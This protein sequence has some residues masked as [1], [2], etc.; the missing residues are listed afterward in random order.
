MGRCIHVTLMVFGIINV[1]RAIL[2][3]VTAPIVLY[4]AMGI[5]GITAGAMMN[6]CGYCSDPHAGDCAFGLNTK[7]I[8]IVSMVNSLFHLAVLI[9]TIVVTTHFMVMIAESWLNK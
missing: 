2:G 7:C 8:A 3:I 5:L 4:V 1:V 6:P 9:H